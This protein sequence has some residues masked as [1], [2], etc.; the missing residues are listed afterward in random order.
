MHPL[1]LVK[2]RF[3]L[4]NNSLPLAP[5]PRGGT[6]TIPNAPIPTPTL[7]PPTISKTKPRLGTA[8]Y[9][10]LRDCVKQDGWAGLYRGLTPNLV[11]GASSWGLYFLL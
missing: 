6:G 4:A 10:A 11:G 1:D 7:I 9:S 5:P 8:V 3:Q 2:V